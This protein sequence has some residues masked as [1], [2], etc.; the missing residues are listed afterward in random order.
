MTIKVNGKGQNLTP[1][2]PLNRSSP[3]FT[4]W[5]RRGYL[6][7]CKISSR[8]DNGFS[9]CACTISCIKLFTRVFVCSFFFGGL[10]I[11]YSQDAHTDF[12]AK[13]VKRRGSVQGCAF[14]GSQNQKLSFTPLLPQKPPFWGPFSRGLRNA[15]NS[16]HVLYKRPLI[17]IVAP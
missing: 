9:F 3:K 1:P 15:F 14:W 5:L 10:Q 11:V 12:D 13:Y 6:P 2:P 4:T 8:L 7:S 17:A 16:G